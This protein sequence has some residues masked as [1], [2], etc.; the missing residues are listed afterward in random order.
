MFLLKIF[1]EF[2]QKP[3]D[4]YNQWLY[5]LSIAVGYTIVKNNNASHSASRSLKIK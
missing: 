5:N 2:F 1:K 4:K 3:L